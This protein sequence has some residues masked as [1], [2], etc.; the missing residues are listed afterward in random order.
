MRKTLKQML[1]DAVRVGAMRSNPVNS[2]RPPRVPVPEPY[3]LETAQAQFLRQA[4]RDWTVQRKKP[5]PA[6]DPRVVD[7]L[8]VMLSVGL[9]IGELLALRH[10]DVDLT[11]SPPRLV[12]AATLVDGA[13]GEPIWPG[14]TKS[15]RHRRVLLL[16]DLAVEALRPYV[17]AT[18]SSAPVFPNRNGAWARPGNVRRILRSFRDEWSEQLE[19]TGIEHDRF[20]PQLL[21]RTLATLIANQAGV[22][23]A[24]EQLGHASVTTTERHYITP[25]RIVGG[26][27]VELIDALFG[28]LPHSTAGG[29]ERPYDDE[30]RQENDDARADGVPS[31]PLQPEREGSLRPASTLVKAIRELVVH[32]GRELVAIM[33][34]CTAGTVDAWL[35]GALWPRDQEA[36]RLIGAYSVWRDIVA[37]ESP[38]TVRAGFMGMKEQLSDRSPAEATANGDV[39]SVRSI[40]RD[41]IEG[42]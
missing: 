16:P 33:A 29:D 4:Y 32:L 39:A 22:D 15:R 35:D 36:G 21:R 30:T 27:T 11:S 42:G 25:P 24:K 2:V 7:M 10:R 31:P 41:F 20:T 3:T 19:S 37:V 1:D 12:V 8:D 34:G 40:A 9:R 6:P 17:M 23:R 13:K 38:E 26:T 14:H 28:R 18:N 5:G